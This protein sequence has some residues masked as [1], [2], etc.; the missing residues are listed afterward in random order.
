MKNESIHDDDDLARSGSSGPPLK[1]IALL[2]LVAG[3]AVFFFQNG[4]DAPVEFMWFDVS[5]PMWG[6][7]GVSVV[8]GILIDRLGAW[9]WNRARRRD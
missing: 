6:V 5:W 1:L 8:V 3:L 7:I 2:V 4:H 9:Q